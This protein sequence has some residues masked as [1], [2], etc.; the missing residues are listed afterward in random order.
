MREITA[1][2]ALV[3]YCGLYCGACRSYLNEKCPGCA[4]NEKATWCK[5]RSC[6][7]EHGQSTCAECKEVQEVMSCKKFNNVISKIFGLIFRSDRNACISQIK[8]LG[9]DGHAAKMAA[10]KKQTIRK[11]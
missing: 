7:K 2:P 6:N 11:K 9:L 5:I 10:E 3:A 8:S 1:D 4:A